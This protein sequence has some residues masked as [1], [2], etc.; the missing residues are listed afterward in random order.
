MKDLS[1]GLA[2]LARLA[3]V[4]A[5]LLSLATGAT[6]QARIP[7]Q[8]FHDELREVVPHSGERALGV[9][10]RT[11]GG[12]DY[13][14]LYVP[15]V[16]PVDGVLCLYVKSLD[17]R[18]TATG[19]YRVKAGNGFVALDYPSKTLGRTYGADEL[20]VGLWY[21]PRCQQL[22]RKF[23][24]ATWT[25]PGVPADLGLAVNVGSS[26]SAFFNKAGGVREY[27]EDLSR[28]Q[29]GRANGLVSHVCWIGSQR[30]YGGNSIRVFRE[31]VAGQTEILFPGL[32]APPE[33]GSH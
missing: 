32:T 24:S 29:P 20:T 19:T 26:A 10:V 7:A 21:A 1:F 2:G 11:P 33:S 3:S 30:L 25:P 5:L 17:G 27:C 12:R 22:D 8:D 15:L 23:I 31:T 9:I 4:T 28:T 13:R 16:A 18:Y 6:A 14:T